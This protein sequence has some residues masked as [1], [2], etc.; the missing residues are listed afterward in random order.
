MCVGTFSYL[1]REHQWRFIVGGRGGGL[2]PA[3]KK[4]Q[5]HSIKNYPTQNANITTY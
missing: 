2:N 3:I 4:K 5:S 1:S